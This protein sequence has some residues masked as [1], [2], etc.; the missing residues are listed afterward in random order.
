[1]NWKNKKIAYRNLVPWPISYWRNVTH[2]WPKHLPALWKKL[3]WGRKRIFV[4]LYFS[5]SFTQF[6]VIFIFI[7]LCY[8]MY[9]YFCFLLL[10]FLLLEKNCLILL[11]ITNA[12]L[13]SLAKDLGI[14]VCSFALCTA[15][16][17][18]STK[19]N[20]ML[21]NNTALKV[22][23]V[24]DKFDLLCMSIS[25]GFSFQFLVV[26]IVWQTLL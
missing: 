26:G 23:K 22:L 12:R 1:M 6:S 24:Y 8:F 16:V 3:I 9:F 18:S 11:Q 5:D 20:P 14:T 2:Q 25:L 13:F 4:E 21:K 17:K 15:A 7:A 19:M 10:L